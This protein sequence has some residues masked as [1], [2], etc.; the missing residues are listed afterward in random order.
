MILI[1]V[2]TFKMNKTKLPVGV[3]YIDGRYYV[4]LSESS[5]TYENASFESPMLAFTYR[6]QRINKAT[7]EL[8]R[9]IE[10]SIGSLNK[11]KKLLTLSDEQIEYLLQSVPRN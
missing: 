5:S 2:R 9:G 1:H 8:N 11:L 6:R 10:N 7:L 3:D 4:R